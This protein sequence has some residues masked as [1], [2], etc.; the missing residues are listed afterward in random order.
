MNCIRSVF[1]L[2]LLS[3]TAFG[4]SSEVRIDMPK[5]VP[6]VGPL[7]RPFHFERRIFSPANLQNTPR[8]E[9][10]VRAGNLYLSVRDV[11]AL[12]LENNLD[13]A[14]QRY[15]PF[16]AQE[17]LR[18]AN[19]GG[20]LRSD[21]N[22]DIIAG[23]QSVST[24]GVSSA[25]SGLATGAGVGSTAGFV[26]GYGPNPPNLDPSITAQLQFAH[27]T[28]PQTN[29]IATG[30]T[31]LVTD[32][33]YYYFAYSQSFITGTSI[34]GSF[35]SSHNDINSPYQ[36][37][38][39]A[40]SG[41]IDFNISQN[42]LQG[43]GKA[44]NNRNIRVA[45][46][47][48]KVMDLTV[49]LQVI[50]TISAVMNLYWDLVSFNEDLRI[51]K[52]AL[53]LAQQL[54]DDNVEQVKLGTLPPIEVTRAAAEVSQRKED[55]LISETNLAQQ[56][57]VLK[58]ALSRN[59][60]ES[61]WLDQVHIIPLDSFEIP[62]LDDAKPVADL[63]QEAL[64]NRPEIVQ[65]RI[66]LES[67]KINVQ[68]TKNSLLPSFGA[69][70]DMNNQGLTGPVN[71]N[72]NGCCGPVNPYFVGGYSN[73]LAQ[74]FRRNFPNYS[75]GFSINIPLRNRQ[76]QADY[77][78]DQLTI[79]QKELQLQRSV[80]QI[81]VD[82][83]NAVI[84]LQQARARYETAV[85]TRKLAE[86]SLRAEQEKFKYGASGTDVTTVIN[87]QKDLVNDQTLEAQAM[88][89]YTHARISFDQAVGRTLDVNHVSMDEAMSGRVAR[90]SV[91]PAS[92]TGEKK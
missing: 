44:V 52:Q 34:Q 55:L 57:T 67:S 13:I 25:G 19:G 84:G 40:T 73:L 23:P 26:I 31:A 76:A 5:P 60:V 50:T 92:V 33:R 83:R 88:A 72:Y 4:Q 58:N 36:L 10:L 41:T 35:T 14:I 22:T 24:A 85:A 64:E 6:V 56:E 28:A 43:F 18:R 91:L 39:P 37:L 71:P 12:T 80:N 65:T 61:V 17:V 48:L 15:G 42:L 49:K 11:I 21:I 62:K 86:E 78:M 68:G 38:N 69:F 9:S 87:A 16:M 46:N 63:I 2:L 90:E 45:K 51:K 70:A 8:L 81:R 79:R 47:N 3:F 75:A 1:F 74:E 27:I 54:Y 29:T 82:V 89:N 30:T 32:S 7:L 59:G 20:L 66:N 53:Q 77:A